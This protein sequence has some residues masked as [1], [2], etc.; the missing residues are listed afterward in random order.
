ME[1][2]LSLVERVKAHGKFDCL[3]TPTVL[4]LESFDFSFFHVIALVLFVCAILH[5]L[6]VNT[7]HTWA[8][9]LELRQKPLRIGKRR[10]RGLGVQCLYFL[11]EVELA[12]AIWAIPLFLIIV[13]TFGWHV[14]VEYINTRDYTEPLF[15]VVIMCLVATRPIVHLAEQLLRSFAKMLGGSLSAWWY[16]LLTLGPLLGSFVTEIGAM[17]LC[18]LLLSRQFYEY[19]PSRALSYATLGLLFVNISVGGVLTDFASP[20]VL[21]LAHCWK[22]SSFSMVTLFGW[23]AAIGIAL[24]NAMY[25]CYFRKEFA[26]LQHKRELRNRIQTPR[27]DEPTTRFPIWV[28]GIHLVTIFWIVL[29]S[30]YPALF[31]GGFLF[32]L[33]FHQATRHYQYPIR[34]MRPLLIGLFLAGLVVH[35]GLQGWWVVR[36]LE[37]LSPLGVLGVSILL[38]GFNDNAAISYLATLIPSWGEAF[39]YALFSGVIAGG[40]L[41]VIANAPNPAGYVLLRRHF[42][43]GISSY[44]LFIAAALPTFI[45][46]LIYIL[47]GPFFG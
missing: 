45:L 18:S 27:P 8:R 10:L 28:T 24:S 31:I 26:L 3:K 16:T 2:F 5:T 33:G 36:L 21:I 39:K 20:A 14:A 44:K 15:I 29:T 22:W 38:T 37:H 30:H 23:K 25:W 41:T 35:G 47:T 12:F 4:E 11:A 32:F 34:L 6:S 19:G 7:I 43:N 42:E 40:G 9:K 13:C 17:A 1:G 46:Y